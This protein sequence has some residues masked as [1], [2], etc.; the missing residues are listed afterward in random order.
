MNTEFVFVEDNQQDI[1]LKATMYY[2]LCR[3]DEIWDDFDDSWN[4]SWLSFYKQEWYVWTMVM[5]D[6][7]YV[8][9]I[10]SKDIQWADEYIQHN[11][12]YDIL[13]QKLDELFSEEDLETINYVDGLYIDEE[14][15][16]KWLWSQLLHYHESVVKNKWYQYSM[17][18]YNTIEKP[19]LWE[20]YTKNWYDKLFDYIWTH[21]HDISKTK[22]KS[23]MIKQ[24]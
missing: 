6:S 8:W 16:S 21:K 3:S 5:K 15:R 19:F 13:S 9:F 1:H 23:L 7:E 20:F 14:Y 22:Q 24:L 11:Y 12:W 10:V 17:L 2:H 18:E 4:N